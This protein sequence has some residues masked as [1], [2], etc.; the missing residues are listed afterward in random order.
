MKSLAHPTM[1]S[2]IALPPYEPLE[3]R[4]FELRYH[5]PLIRPLE[6]APYSLLTSASDE[7]PAARVVLV[8]RL[9]KCKAVALC[10]MSKKRSEV[11]ACG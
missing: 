11:L 10:T 3:E 9:V 8:Y 7:K 4:H 2:L 6:H 1:G 5:Q